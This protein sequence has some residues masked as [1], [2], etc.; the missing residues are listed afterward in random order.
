MNEVTP[1]PSPAKHAWF[2]VSRSAPPKRSAV[3]R[4]ADFLEVYG[5]YD[6]ETARAQAS[7]CLQCPEPLC[8]AG[9][10]LASRIP[11]WLLLTA[12]GQFMEAAALTRSTSNLPEICARVCPT[13]R[14][15]E[16][17]CILNGKA[18]P[19]SIAALERF[20]NEYAFAHGAGEVLPVP[21][22]GFSVAVVGS[23]PV[24]L[25]CADELAKRGYAVTVFDARPVPGGLLVN[26]IPAFKLERS[27]V[28]RRIALL[29][30]RGIRFELNTH[31]GKDVPLR[32]LRARFDAV[33]LGFGAPR[34][35]SLTV[36]GAKRSGVHVALP[37]LVQHTTDVPLD[38]APIE[39]AGRR[40]VVLGAGDTA[41]D[42]LRTA[43]RR[44]ARE[45]I[46]V[47]RRDQANLPGSRREFENTVEEGARF[48]WLATPAEVLGDAE[49][50]VRGVRCLRTQ[51]G[52]PDVTG[53]RKPTPLPGTEFD[54][55]AD[56]ILVAFGFEPM[57]F[58]AGS[59]LS[60]IAINDQGMVIV[61]ARQMTNLPGVFAG[62]DLVR[63]PSL[64]VHAVRDAR[65]A[66]LEI[67]RYLYSRKVRDLLQDQ[68]DHLSP[69]T[70]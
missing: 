27:V 31:I 70:L 58:P 13:D 33:F 61:D 41:M 50:K 53:R 40:V 17:A 46:C 54:V 22:N 48:I 49:G 9:C 6:E 68:T 60:Q 1:V 45:T 66:A 52:G 38:T 4:V 5:S 14:L 67:H 25:A 2:E 10:P 36:P 35:R 16:G 65:K 56:V 3:E 34:S 21:P 51:L 64:V 19:V 30:R 11:E 42:C 29:R 7:R 24:G 44:G 8:V 47:Y 23:G 32:E 62:G 12:E 43:I 55:A 28:D 26:G 15:C 20:L 39:V 18:E 63:G 69:E 59:D 37:F 57:P